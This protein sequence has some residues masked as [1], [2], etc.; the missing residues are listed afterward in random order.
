MMEGIRLIFHSVA[1]R[2]ADRLTELIGWSGTLTLV[3]VMGL[4]IIDLISG[5][6]QIIALIVS[7]AGGIATYIYIRKKT[8]QLERPHGDN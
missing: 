3:A 7:I 8:R 2:V 6:L 5:I 1:E 4:S